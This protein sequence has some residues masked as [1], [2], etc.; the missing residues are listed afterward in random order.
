M[1]TTGILAALFST[2]LLSWATCLSADDN[3]IELVEYMCSLQYFTHKLQLSLEAQ[4]VPL[5]EFYAHEIEEVIELLKSVDSYDG[6][7]IG[8]LSEAM[9][10]PQFEKFEQH[11][12]QNKSNKTLE[13]FDGIID[14]CR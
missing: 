1:K 9:L 7:P 2:I 14:S 3:D 10:I 13:S 5:A 8:K 6:Y 12:K 11:L 4:N